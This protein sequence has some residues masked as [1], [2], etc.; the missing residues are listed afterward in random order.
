METARQLVRE[1][2]ERR[3]E[4]TPTD[5]SNFLSD[6]GLRYTP[7]EV[8]DEI[9]EIKESLDTQQIMVRPAFCRQCEFD[10]WDNLLN[11]PSR[12]PNCR[13]KWIREP[14]FTIR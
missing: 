3:P 14:A 8:L 6:K 4:P 5:L 1:E 13:S 2:L 9:A 10:D 11:I 12:C 7:R